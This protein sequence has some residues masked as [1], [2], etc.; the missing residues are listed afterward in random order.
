[1]AGSGKTPPGSARAPAWKV[2]VLGVS[3]DLGG[4]FVLSVLLS[5]VAGL[6]L[7][8]L[9]SDEGTVRTL[10]ESGAWTA[11][12]F[13]AG[14]ACTVLGA[15][16]AARVANRDEYGFALVSSLIALALGELVGS[17]SDDMSSFMLRVAGWLLTA[18]LALLGARIRVIQKERHITKG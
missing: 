16:V 1:M 5:I 6:W 7:G 14:S 15:Y 9:A 18:P 11:L 12:G 13:A 3:A 17:G 10:M 4:T 2:I 8:E